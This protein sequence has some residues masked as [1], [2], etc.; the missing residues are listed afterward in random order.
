MY[1]PLYV[2]FASVEELQTL[3]LYVSNSDA[4]WCEYRFCNFGPARSLRRS[5]QTARNQNRAPMECLLFLFVFCVAE[6]F[7]LCPKGLR[8]PTLLKQGCLVL[9][10]QSDR[11]HI[12]VKVFYFFVNL[13]IFLIYLSI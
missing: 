3:S 4:P 5:R 9:N 6:P 10:M 13:L 1:L 8:F 12:L 2:D 11:C 7:S